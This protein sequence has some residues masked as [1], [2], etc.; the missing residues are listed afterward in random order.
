MRIS[1][2]AATLAAAALCSAAGPALPVIA[3]RNATVHTASG[4]V[5][6]K[7]TV[8]V[9]NGLIEAVGPSV[10]APADA[11]VLEAP[12]LHVY[13]GLTDAMSSWGLPAATPPAA[14]PGA[15][16]APPPPARGPEDRPSNSSWVR[17]QDLV[18]PSDRTVT[19]ARNAGFTTAAVF[20]T[21]GIFAGQGALVNL[22]GEK[23]GQMTVA[24]PLGQYLSLSPRGF[25]SFPGSLMGVV[26]Y[27]RQV[28]LDADAYRAEKAAYA[29]NPRG[30]RRPAYDRALEGVLES[31][32]LL[33][34]AVWAKELV[35]MTELAAEFK[36]PTILYGA[37]DAARV[38]PYLAKSGA[39]VL[40][41]LKWPERARD[42]D[43]EA[44]E[45]LRI[46]ELRENAPAAPAALAKAGVKFAFYAGGVERP[47]DLRAAVKKAI[48]AG[49]D[50][51]AAVRALTLSA[52]EIYG[53]ADHTGSIE[54]GKIA[55]LTITDGALFQTSTKI[56]FVLIDG[57]KYEPAPEAPARQQQEE[58]R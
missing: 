8:V 6:E 2:I 10:T 13:P 9:R 44:D 26:A 49:L 29:A 25:T 52:A 21:A 31:P 23:A 53:V 30:A 41:S 20:P 33:L 5:L 45:A 12:S 48:D 1:M 51:E 42:P 35:R 24:T 19:A 38:A 56:K 27:V 58:K 34:P 57:V 47:A 7:S 15:A 16:T 3:I 46:L 4:P 54:P 50:R 39:A 28:Y 37:H 43:P 17:A 14:G 40:V 32:R 11:W 55:N 36:R 18:N 22:A